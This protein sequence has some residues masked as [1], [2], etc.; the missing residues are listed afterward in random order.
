MCAHPGVDWDLA[1]VI[2]KKRESLQEFIQHF[3]KK[4]DVIPEVD[5][6]SIAMFFKKGLKDPALIRKLAMKI[7][8]ML[9]AI[10]AIDNKYALAVEATLDTRE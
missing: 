1:S 9:E 6:K 5:D 3:C 8:R 7:P 4:R 2:Q 10:L